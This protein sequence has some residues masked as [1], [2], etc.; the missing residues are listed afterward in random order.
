M[1]VKVS[2]AIFDGNPTFQALLA[3]GV[4]VCVCVCVCP[5]EAV[6]ESANSVMPNKRMRRCCCPLPEKI[7]ISGNGLYVF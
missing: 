1:L 5:V 4:C 2:L 3:Q 6:A 7:L